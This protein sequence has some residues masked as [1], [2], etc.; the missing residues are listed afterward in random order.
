M[1]ILI[2]AFFAM[3]AIF[4]KSLMAA[5]GVL[6]AVT[7]FFVCLIALLASFINGLVHS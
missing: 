5:I 2:T 6:L 7:F 3:L 1:T 4:F